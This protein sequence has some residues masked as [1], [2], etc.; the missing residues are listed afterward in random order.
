MKTLRFKTGM[1]CNGCVSSVTPYLNQVKGIKS[2]NVELTV[3]QSTLEVESDEDIEQEIIDAVKN[4][5]YMIT[6][7]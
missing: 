1:K 2:W 6:K 7:E 5:G 3:P 4:A